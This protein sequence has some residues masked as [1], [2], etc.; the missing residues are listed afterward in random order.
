VLLD[1]CKSLL[2]ILIELLTPLVV[3]DDELG[4]LVKD[5]GDVV[6]V[7]VFVG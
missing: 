6:S 1:L 5:S 2:T 4:D 3:G 7:E